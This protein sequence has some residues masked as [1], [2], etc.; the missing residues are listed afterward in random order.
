MTQLLN[1]MM[2]SNTEPFDILFR[3]LFEADAFFMPAIESKPKYPIN[4]FESNEGLHFEIAC[5]GLSEKDIK[6]DI[7]EGDTLTISHEK[8]STIEDEK[9]NYIHKGIAQRAFSLGWKIGNKFNLEEIEASMDKGLLS[10]FI[11]LAPDKLP[12]SIS[13]KSANQ[14]KSIK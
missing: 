7:K 10:I 3:N 4:I 5:V 13:I 9:R 6:L 8:D 11:P 1:R 12:K 2:H 14:K